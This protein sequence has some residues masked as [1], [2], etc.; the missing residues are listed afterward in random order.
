MIDVKQASQ[1]AL[2]HFASLYPKIDSNDI[3][4]EEAEL[5]E[6]EKYWIITISY[7][8]PKGEK[9]GE[10]FFGE[11]RAFKTFKLLSDTGEVRSMKI[12][13]SK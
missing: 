7:K 11:T 3:M 2:E 13:T 12:R 9:I 10:T 4:L 8:I 5:T 6:D 1:K